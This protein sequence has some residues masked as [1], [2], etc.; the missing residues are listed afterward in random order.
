MWARGH[1]EWIRSWTTLLKFI[2]AEKATKFCK[3]LTL[4][5]STVHIDKSKVKISQN[6]VV[7][8]EYMNF[9]F[10][11]KLHNPNDTIEETRII[12]F[13]C[14]LMTPC[15][16]I[17]CKVKQKCILPYPFPLPCQRVLFYD[18]LPIL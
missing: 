11:E 1:L 16:C 14:F 5:L 13:P 2:Y 10:L 7:F 6:F 18:F 15:Y 12:G 8:S 9:T 17:Q 3:I 4:L